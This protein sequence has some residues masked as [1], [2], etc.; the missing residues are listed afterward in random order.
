[1][2]TIVYIILLVIFFILG[3]L[4]KIKKRSTN[5]ITI[6]KQGAVS[7]FDELLNS[8][9]MSDIKSIKVNIEMRKNKH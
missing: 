4:F 8:Y 3:Y 2:K 6:S 1:M 5:N 9:D 7:A